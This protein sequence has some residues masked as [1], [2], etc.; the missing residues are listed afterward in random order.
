M[1]IKISRADYDLLWQQA[2]PSLKMSEENDFFE[3]RSLAPEQIGQGYI[4]KIQWSGIELMI[5]NYRLHDDLFVKTKAHHTSDPCREIGFNLS[6]NRCGKHTG[7]S[8][9]EWGH[10]EYDSDTEWTS[11]TYANDEIRKVDI[12][13]NSSESLTQTVSDTLNRLPRAISQKVTTGSYTEEINRITPAMRVALEQIFCCPFQGK[14]KQLYLESKCLELIALKL[15][16]IQG[17][18]T[19]SNAAVLGPDDIERIYLAE[20]I[21]TQEIENPPSLV[22]LAKRVKLNEHKLKVGFRQV[23]DTTVFGYL[24]RYRMEKARQLLDQQRMNVKEV[25][26]AVGYANQSRFAVAFRREFGINPK[27]YFLSRRSGWGEKR[28]G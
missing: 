15:E 7:E 22:L 26:R 5:F 14:T 18:H 6:G 28:S 27:A 1:A 9:I 23:F 21:L 20:N 8:F 3:V 25:S 4:Q 19:Q 13:L 10:N 11:V 12:H 17:I 2:N 24:H 16:Q